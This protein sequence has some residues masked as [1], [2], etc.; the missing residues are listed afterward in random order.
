MASPPQ[1]PTPSPTQAD[2]TSGLNGSDPSPKR[3]ESAPIEAPRRT[4]TD[5]SY[6]SFRFL[7]RRNRKTTHLSLQDWDHHDTPYHDYVRQL[8]A[9]GWTNLRDLDNYMST[10]ATREGLI[11]SV[12]DIQSDSK[13][14]QW[15]EMY[16]ELELKNFLSSHSRNGV[17]VRFYMVENQGTPSPALIE[18]LGS[19]LNLDPRFFQWI[20]HNKGHIFTPSQRHNAPYLALGFGVLRET[21]VS[22]TDAEKFKVMVYILVSS[23][24]QSESPTTLCTFISAA[25]ADP[26]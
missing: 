5:T 14:K 17:K 19:S 26:V 6:N 1:Y 20:I 3:A 7:R 15:P 11:V 13:R 8:V 16:N 4:D 2:I 21:T 10:A 25:P 18:T 22:V 12:L 24:S 9:A 23:A